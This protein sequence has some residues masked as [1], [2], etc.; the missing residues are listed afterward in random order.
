MITLAHLFPLFIVLHARNTYPIRQSEKRPSTRVG[1]DSLSISFLLIEGTRLVVLYGMLRRQNRALHSCHKTQFSI[2]R[3]QMVIC[4]RI[5]ITAKPKWRS[6]L[7][8]SRVDVYQILILNQSRER[9]P[10]REAFH[11]TLACQ[12][13]RSYWT[14][15]WN[16]WH[17]WKYSTN[18]LGNK[19]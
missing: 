6:S 3:S 15:Q 10:K 18:R 8:V 19:I 5:Q 13:S 4:L 17:Y 1:G 7:G 16:S 2:A 9:W 11:P 12:K 14:Q